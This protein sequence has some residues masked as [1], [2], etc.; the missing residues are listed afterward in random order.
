MLIGQIDLKYTH[1]Q[2]Q[3]K[4]KKTTTKKIKSTTCWV[5]VFAWHLKGA[6]GYDLFG[7]TLHFLPFELVGCSCCNNEAQIKVINGSDAA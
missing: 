3:Q 7:C 1:Q 4:N 5:V 6:M 2:Q